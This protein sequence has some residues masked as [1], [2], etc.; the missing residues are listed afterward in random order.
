MFEKLMTWKSRCT[1]R[2]FSIDTTK[3]PT[4]ITVS[5][6]SGDL[7]EVV[8]FLLMPPKRAW[9]DFSLEPLETHVHYAMLK[10]QQRGIEKRDQERRQQSSGIG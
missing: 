10:L 3:A 6:W 7:T 5:L 9:E 8:E 2:R 4:M 1:D